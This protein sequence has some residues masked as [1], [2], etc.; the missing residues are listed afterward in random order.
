MAKAPHMTPNPIRLTLSLLFLLPGLHAQQVEN[1]DEQ[2][3]QEEQKT[4][5][6]SP[7]VLEEDSSIGYRATATLAGSRLRTPLGDVGAAIQVVT[8]ELM[9]DTGATDASTLLSYTINTEVGGAQGNFA[10]GG[11]DLGGDRA[12][13]NTARIYPELN[14]R[15]RGLGEA[16]LTRDFFL[17]SIP[18]DA[19]NSTQVTINRGPNSILFGVGSPGGII[20]NS[21]NKASLA[22]NSGQVAARVGE[23]GSYRATLDLNRILIP[24]RLAVRIAALD[25]SHQY[26]Q[27]P[28]YDDDSRIYGAVEFIAF[29]N[30]RSRF[31]DRTVI[32]ANHEQGRLKSN[33]PMVIPPRSLYHHWWTP[34]TVDYEKYTGTPAQPMHTTQFVPQYT[35]SLDKTPNGI[36]QANTPTLAWTSLFDQGALFYQNSDDQVPNAATPSFPDAHGLQGRLT[37]YPGAQRYEWFST[38]A[39]EGQAY[40]TGFAYPVI[41][42][43]DVFDYRKKLFSGDTSLVERDF[44]TYNVALEQLFFERRN[45]GIE[46]VYD[47]QNWEPY[48]SMPV[49]DSLQSIYSNADI[50]IDISEKLGTGDV[51][52]NLGRPYIRLFDL[53]GYETR[54]VDREAGRATAFYDLDFGDIID[55]RW[56]K[57]LGRHT[58][59]GFWGTQRVTSVGRNNRANWFSDE[60]DMDADGFAGP[61]GNFFR[62][63]NGIVYVGPSALNASG[64]DEVRI[65]P[66]NIP[67][68][69]GGDTYRIWYQGATGLARFDDSLKANNFRVGHVLVGAN[70]TRNEIDSEAFT[71]QSRLLNN[72][73]VGLV[74]WR[75]DEASSFER[76][77]TEQ[78][79]E[80]TG[81]SSRTLPDGN[82]KPENL[83]LQDEPSSIEKGDTFTSSV[84]AHVPERWTTALPLAPRF[85]VHYGKSENFS[86]AGLRR[87][88]YLNVLSPPTGETT[89]YGFSVELSRKHFMRFNWFETESAGADAGLNA[90]L[91]T[92]RTAYR[93][94]R[95]VAEPQNTGWTFAETKEAMIVALGGQDPIPNINSFAEMEAAI[96]GLVPS[97]IMSQLNYRVT[98]DEAGRYRVESETFA[99]QVATAA[100]RAKG[101]EIDLVSNPTPNWRIMFNV[102][103]QETVQSDSATLAK[104]LSDIIVDNIRSSGLADLRISPTFNAPE[105]VYNEYNRLVLVPLNGV[106]AKDGTVSLEQRKWRANMVTNYTFARDS[107]LRG[108]RVGGAVRWQDKV[109]IG[110]GQLY[111]PETGIVPDLSTPHFAPSEWNGDVWIGYQRKLTEKIRWNVQ[112]NF[113]NAFGDNGDIPVRSNPDGS[114]AVIRIPN[115]RTWF[116]TNT[117][118]F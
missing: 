48:W 116:L 97:E 53:G 101:F 98:Q 22:K 99:G 21:L 33:P 67:I 47:E 76:L 46:I 95:M 27:R 96:V 23:H 32:R 74:G 58:F 109:A 10:G 40:G 9:E 80:R 57:W 66:V 34:P 56:G 112:L 6:L 85:S 50:A 43:R 93:L 28:A 30:E 16:T 42:N 106:L 49:N 75:T 91:V 45:A 110:Y 72:H 108:F 111:S 38:Q 35:V 20:D 25:E 61:N 83:I 12:D 18:F 55:S 41:Q 15:V 78:I 65:H 29:K 70:I 14:Q 8:K 82:M 5:E 115:E 64:P 113:R 68:P 79:L 94:E 102:A 103:K 89:E 87:D 63:V 104:Q 71:I 88:V 3:E 4:I 117:F 107:R 84:V 60:I 24:D 44:R 7:F 36:T 69:Q 31:L 39:A 51:N 73:V 90:G 100:V 54:Q 26:D 77:T 37:F 118:S 86:P 11:T 62:A 1:R 114:I 2:E 105:T 19:Y 59:T 92:N 17:T 13:Q 52:P 81:T